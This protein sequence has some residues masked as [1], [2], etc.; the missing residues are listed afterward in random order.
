MDHVGGADVSGERFRLFRLA[1]AALPK[2]A[3]LVVAI[4][5]LGPGDSAAE[6]YLAVETGLKCA[7]C[8]VNPTGGGKRNLFGMTYARG[9]IAERLILRDEE[10]R[11]WNSEI[12]SWLGL[13]GD[14]RG[15]YSSVDMEVG[16]DSSG[17]DTSKATLYLELR[18]I[19]GL[20]S[21]YADEQL[22]P[23]DELN[24][25]AY[26][27]LTPEQGKYTIKVGQMFLPFGLRIQDDSTFVRQ[28]SG[29]NFTTP[30]EGIELGLELPQWSAQAA[31]SDGTAG[32]GD[33]PGKSQTSLSATYV[34]SRWRVGLSHNLSEDP[35]GDREMQALFAGWRTGPISWLAEVDWITDEDP[36]GGDN[37]IFATLL[38][39]NWRFRKGHNLKV[40]YEFLEPSDRVDEDE[41]ERYSVVWE[42]S[43]FQLF[44]TRAGWRVYNGVPLIP[45]TNRS[46]LFLEFHAYF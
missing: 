30:D 39:G 41:E 13:G 26:V 4:F 40:G 21:I 25:E 7:N 19:P 28:R 46:E 29:I 17:W 15:G 44:Q 20:L 42:Y 32:A 3:W 43:P 14:Y 35:V 9:N 16:E 27:L 11:D 2:A 36:A 12:N 34:Q 1:V 6:P 10:P 8:H 33:L 23:G 38:E 5:L 24:R 31:Y 18:A 22:A 37:E 45:V